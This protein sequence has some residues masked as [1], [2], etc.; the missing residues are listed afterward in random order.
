MSSRFTCLFYVDQD[1]DSR[2]A[3]VII[4]SQGLSLL[5]PDGRIDLPWTALRA[6]RGG[7]DH[8]LLV[9]RGQLAGHTYSLFIKD[10]AQ[11]VKAILASR[12]HPSLANDLQ[13]HFSPSRTLRWIAAGVVV[14]ALLGVG[15]YYGAIWAFRTTVDVAVANIPTDWEL[16]L[17]R[18]SAKEILTQKEVCSDPKVVAAVQEIVERLNAAVVDSPYPFTV[19]IVNTP[20]VNA[21][22]LPGGYI[23]VHS[24]LLEK[25]GSPAEVAGVIAHEMQH[26][27]KRHGLR[28]VMGR[29]SLGLVAGLVF[30]DIQGLG[31]FAVGAASELA[32]LSFSR[33]QEVE[34][35]TGGL[36]LLYAASID[37]NGMPAFFEVLIEEEQKRSVGLPSFLSS[38]PETLDRIATLRAEIQRR[39]VVSAKPFDFDW[40]QTRTLCTPI[41]W[42]DP[43]KAVEPKSAP[44]L[45]S[46]AVPTA[47]PAAS[48][49]LG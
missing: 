8:S 15:L 14:L 12:P 26:A 34:A 44:S 3:E 35:D 2:N 22:A 7:F 49:S 13:R 19:K 29:A 20:E 10:S 37:P 36:E 45:P 48:A 46:P 31:G 38:H 1:A 9:L 39:G 32:A 28:N 47:P 6:D 21:F 42:S 17:G 30:G 5:L 43:D 40:T 18:Y 23:F 24:G 25:A 16:E 4:Q 11:A 27:L 33:E 41:P